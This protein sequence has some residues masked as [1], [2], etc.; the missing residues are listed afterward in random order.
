M[1][2]LR[3][4]KVIVQPIYVIDDGDL[5]EQAAQPIEVSA[6]DWPTFPEKLEAERKTQEAA[7][8]GEEQSA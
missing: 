2:S 7:L 5:T 6:V 1:N 8:T 4:L 3:L